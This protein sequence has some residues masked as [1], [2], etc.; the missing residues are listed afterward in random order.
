[1]PSSQV[2]LCLTS[3]CCLIGSPKDLAVA[4]E[5]V[6]ELSLHTDRARVVPHSQT[7]REDQIR[8]LSG[9]HVGT[10]RVFFCFHLKGR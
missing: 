4:H 2:C 6:A 1:M 8:H 3:D 7:C 10:S 5:Q 9:R